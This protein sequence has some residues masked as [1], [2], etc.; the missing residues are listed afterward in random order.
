SLHLIGDNI[1]EGNALKAADVNGDGEVNL[2]DLAH[3][4]RYVSQK[5]D[6]LGPEDN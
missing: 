6:V 1:L 4:R 3:L 2:S 5:T